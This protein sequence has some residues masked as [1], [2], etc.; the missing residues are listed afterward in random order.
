MEEKELILSLIEGTSDIIHSVAPDGRFEFVNKAW[1]Q[2][3]GY[4]D[5][6]WESMNL[7]DIIF[8]GQLKKHS[9]ILGQI[10]AGQ[11]ISDIEVTFVTKDGS[12]IYAE[13]N[14]FPRR[15]DNVIVA[16]TG[17]YRNISSRKESEES[18]K[19][20]RERTEFF[21]D[22]MV[23]DISNINQEIISTLEILLLDKTIPEQL[24]EFVE[25]ALSE[26][27][28]SS[29]LVE[30]V[31]KISSLYSLTPKVEGYDLRTTIGKASR[32]VEKS[33]PDRELLLKTN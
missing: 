2:T 6:E 24:K 30:N 4:G 26:A 19:V 25:E 17:F 21:V 10:L 22:L 8:P 31:R 7:K 33:F 32:K 14:M 29:S 12:I 9:E 28:R 11:R 5:E 23:H 1:L 3:L 15:V 16:A 13:G 18:L 27:E 20:Q